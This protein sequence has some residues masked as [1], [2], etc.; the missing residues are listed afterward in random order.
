MTILSV[1][2]TAKGI[3]LTILGEEAG[4]RG[5]KEQKKYAPAHHYC[6]EDYEQAARGFVGEHVLDPAG[7]TVVSYRGLGSFDF[8]TKDLSFRRSGWRRAQAK[9]SSSASIRNA[10]IRVRWII[11]T[12]C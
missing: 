1:I 6:Q 12:K 7:C 9:A 10:E 8:D 3:N 11:R 2:W 4:D 5:V